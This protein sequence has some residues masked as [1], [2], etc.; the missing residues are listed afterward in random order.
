LTILDT[1]LQLLRAQAV[2]MTGEA[3]TFQIME[4]ASGG[5]GWG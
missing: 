3:A 2:E 1:S 5:R 4:R